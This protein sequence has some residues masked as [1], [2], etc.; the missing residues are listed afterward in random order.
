MIDTNG[1]I[2]RST[3]NNTQEDDK[4]GDVVNDG[5]SPNW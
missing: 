1:T 3:H 5:A 4:E 2:S